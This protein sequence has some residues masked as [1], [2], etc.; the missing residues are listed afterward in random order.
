M[1]EQDSFSNAVIVTSRKEL[2]RQNL[3]LNCKTQKLPL[4]NG[5]LASPWA[6]NKKPENTCSDCER[7]LKLFQPIAFVVLPSSTCL[8][9]FLFPGPTGSSCRVVSSCCTRSQNNTTERT[10]HSKPEAGGSLYYRTPSN[11]TLSD[12]SAV[13]C[14]HHTHAQRKRGRTGITH[15][16][17]NYRV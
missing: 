16:V 17:A 7:P 2:T 6:A 13:S 15:W 5:T 8:L 3:L 4:T 1:C 10:I 11:G 12:C 9:L 14:N